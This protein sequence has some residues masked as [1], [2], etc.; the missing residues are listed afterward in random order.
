MVCF[1]YDVKMCDSTHVWCECVV[2]TIS[3]TSLVDLFY[4]RVIMGCLSY[5]EQV[6]FKCSHGIVPFKFNDLWIFACFLWVITMTEF[7]YNSSNAKDDILISHYW[8]Y[9]GL[10]M[11][12]MTKDALKKCLI[13]LVLWDANHTLH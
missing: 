11:K 12:C 13:V 10:M 7:L 2:W 1:P 8:L 6:D 5:M 4:V 3:T 9:W